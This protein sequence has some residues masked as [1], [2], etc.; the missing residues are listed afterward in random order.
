[1]INTAQDMREAVVNEIVRAMAPVVETIQELMGHAD[2]G[3]TLKCYI[4]KGQKRARKEWQKYV[5]VA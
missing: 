3:T 1:M 4:A 5:Y 2:A